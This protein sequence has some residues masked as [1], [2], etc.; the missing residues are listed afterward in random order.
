VAEVEHLVE[1]CKRCPE[2]SFAATA[3]AN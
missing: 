2:T 1:P 3:A